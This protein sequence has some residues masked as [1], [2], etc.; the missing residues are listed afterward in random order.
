[1]C[2]EFVSQYQG[3]DRGLCMI[4]VVVMGDWE[5]VKMGRGGVG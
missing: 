5:G 3:L 1:M 4:A 2:G